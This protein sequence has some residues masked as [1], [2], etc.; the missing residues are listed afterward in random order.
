MLDA[1]QRQYDQI[2]SSHT[3]LVARGRSVAKEI[4]QSDDRMFGAGSSSSSAAHVVTREVEGEVG[5]MG[6]GLVKM[7]AVA[8]PKL[9]QHR[10]CLQYHLLQQRN[11]KVGD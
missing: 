7:E 1:F 10:D 4:V 9:Q 5:R 11:K 8:G 2:T 6:R 3:E